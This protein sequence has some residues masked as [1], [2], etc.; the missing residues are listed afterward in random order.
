MARTKIAIEPRKQPR[1]KRAA[2]TV[3]V[4]LEASARILQ[5]E[6]LAGFNTNEV[7]RVAGV[8]VG[9]LYQ[10]FPTKEAILAEIVRRKRARL[11]E[12]LSAELE[13]A[14]EQDFQVTVRRLVEATLRHQAGNQGLARALDYA[15]AALPLQAETEALNG[16][17]IQGIADILPADIRPDRITVARDIV[18]IVRGMIDSASTSDSW[19]P[20]D[21]VS[22]ICRAVDGYLS[23]AG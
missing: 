3:D 4:V 9:S 22:R 20:G 15:Y 13:L 19:P 12:A 5:K 17:I 2:A 8:S 14:G 21:I 10:Y 23:E 11:W 7:A 1:Q 16:K 6:G 18:A